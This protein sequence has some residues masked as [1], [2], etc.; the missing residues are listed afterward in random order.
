MTLQDWMAANDR[1]DGELADAWGL[2]QA[3]VNRLRNGKRKPGR[4]L[5]KQIHDWTD[6]AVSFD[7]W[8]DA[9]AAAGETGAAA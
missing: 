1:K 7:D 3:Q 6:G 4:D 5:M 8:F 2:S 9:D